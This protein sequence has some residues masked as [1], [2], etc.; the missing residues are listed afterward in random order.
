MNIDSLQKDAKL[1]WNIEHIR[2]QQ[3]QHIMNS[4]KEGKSI[5]PSCNH[6][7]DGKFFLLY[8][9]NTHASSV[10]KY[11]IAVYCLQQT[12]ILFWLCRL[13]KAEE[14]KLTQLAILLKIHKRS[15][16]L[17]VSLVSITIFRRN[18]LVS[19]I[20]LGDFSVSSFSFG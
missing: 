14:C 17:C 9:Y 1:W 8:F 16:V 5:K 10:A 6:E 3:R 12:S 11:F 20:F 13:Q 7:S 4:K 19:N 18:V 15:R 2:Q